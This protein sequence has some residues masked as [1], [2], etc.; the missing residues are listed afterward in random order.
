MKLY[1]IH[2][3]I[4]IF[5]QA[6]LGQDNKSVFFS[7]LTTN[8]GLSQSYVNC[9][10]KDKYGFLW[11]GTED[12]LNKYD[13]CKYKVFRNNPGNPKTI[14]NNSI[15]CLFE[16]KSGELWAGTT[17]GGITKYNRGD[18]SFTSYGGGAILCIYENSDSILWVGTFHG[19]KVFDRKTRKIIPASSEKKQLAEIENLLTSS[20]YEDSHKNLWIVNSNGIFLF[21]EKS[22]ILR[23]I[24]YFRIPG[25]DPRISK[26][27]RTGTDTFGQGPVAGCMLYVISTI[28]L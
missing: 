15:M 8:D 26:F 25:S 13:G 28:R 17:G 16:D 3:L 5:P 4:L 21:H 19:L 18:D 7:H 24:V 22:G 2:L 6:I 20:I 9:I 27:L 14:P 23:N 10:L 12:G 1:C 11:F